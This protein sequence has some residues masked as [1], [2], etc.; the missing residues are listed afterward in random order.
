ML[1][2]SADTHTHIELH[3]WFSSLLSTKPN[4]TQSLACTQDG[5]RER[6]RERE[7]VSERERV[8]ESERERGKE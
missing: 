6:E 3:P 4:Q 7:R 2:P 8:R 1:F 5:E